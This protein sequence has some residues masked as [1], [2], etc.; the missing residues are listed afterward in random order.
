MSAFYQVVPSDGM[1]G[2]FG[3]GLS[4]A[5]QGLL[6]PRGSLVVSTAKPSSCGVIFFVLSASD[7]VFSAKKSFLLKIKSH[8]TGLIAALDRV[9]PSK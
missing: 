8:S 3:H 5:V 1:G 4:A 9:L 7:S 6:R 2:A